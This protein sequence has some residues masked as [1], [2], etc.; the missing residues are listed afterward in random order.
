MHLPEH[1]SYG[2]PKPSFPCR[3]PSRRR[4]P[5]SKQR[6]KQGGRITDYEQAGSNPKGR[7]ADYRDFEANHDKSYLYRTVIVRLRLKAVD[8]SHFLNSKGEVP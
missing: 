1:D 5:L 7:L 8:C 3:T 4:S 6:F 2:E